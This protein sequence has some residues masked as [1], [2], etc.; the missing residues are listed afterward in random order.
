[1]LDTIEKSNQEKKHK[2]KRRPK[3]QRR[4][5]NVVKHQHW[6]QVTEQHKHK[7]RPK[8]QRR[9]TNVVKHQH[10][11]QETEQHKQTKKT[12]GK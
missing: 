3:G 12:T 1:L 8:G 11:Q 5:T 7:R 4:M 10:W 6:Q 9:M 2:H